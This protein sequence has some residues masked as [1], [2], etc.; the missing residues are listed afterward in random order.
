MAE[1]RKKVLGSLQPDIEDILDWNK[2]PEDAF[3]P[4][5]AEEKESFIQDRKSVSYW[6]DAWRRLRRNKVAMVAMV[7]VILLGL[8]AFVG[9][10][11]V[12]YSYDEVIPGANNLHP[13]HYSLEDQEELAAA[14]DPEKAIELARAEA[15]AEGRELSRIEEAQIRAQ[16]K[17]GG[18]VDELRAELGI[19]PKLFGY[20]N[21]ELQRIANGESV[22]PHVFGCD[23]QGRDIMVRTMIGT[24]VSM[25]VGICCALIVLVIGAIYG[26]I[27]GYC[28][29]KVDAVMQRIVEIIYTIPEVLII[30]L[31]GATLKPILEDFQNSGDGFF[32]NMVTILGP[33]LI[34]IFIAFGLLY[35]VTMSRIIRGQILQ[36]KQQEYVTAARALGAKGGRIIK[37]HLLPNCV[38]Q[39]VTTTFLQIPSAIFTESFLS[40]L[41]MGVSAPM[42]SLGSMCSDG[43]SGLQSYPYRLFIPAIILSILILC[44]NL[45]G[46][47]LRDALDPRLKK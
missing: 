21:D 39:I 17:S 1:K 18:D 10:L 47:G 25:I 35:W 34:A 14:Q 30:L 20:T 2:L 24:R 9:P 38:G 45:F 41:G 13:W 8:F 36:L 40:F 27:S 23:M 28:G 5:S 33:N 15:E 43:L 19:K 16:V 32:Q 29:G 44:L 37:R 4:A 46:D 31:L 11:I 3:Q 26:S 22:F 42:T 6:K 12:P 7:I